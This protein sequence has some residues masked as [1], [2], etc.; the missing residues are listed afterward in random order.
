MRYIPFCFLLWALLSWI[1]PAYGESTNYGI[2]GNPGAVDIVV[3]TGELGRRIGI[4]ESSGVRLGGVWLGDY[5]ALLSGRQSTHVLTGTSS[6][7]VD[8]SINFEKAIGWTG[9]MFGVEFLQSNGQPTNAHTGP[10]P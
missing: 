8:F 10:A 1:Q 4:P 5:N 9:G 3:G 6:L 2:S 7:I